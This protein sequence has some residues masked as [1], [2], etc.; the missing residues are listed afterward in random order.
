M[1]SRWSV[2]TAGLISLDQIHVP[3]RRGKMFATG[4]SCGNVSAN[5]AALGCE[6]YPLS[7]LGL[8]WQGE[9]VVNELRSLGA[10]MDF[11]TRRGDVRTPIVIHRIFGETG[12]GPDHD[13]L[14]VDPE[15]LA[16][17]PRF[18]SVDQLA[19][20]CV[21]GSGI[22]PSVFYL[23][24][25]SPEL[26]DAA[27]WV[28]ARSARVIFE[29][30]GIDDIALFRAIDGLADI[31]KYASHC[32]MDRN[33]NPLVDVKAPIEIQTLGAAEIRVGFRQQAQA[34][35]GVLTRD[36]HHLPAL[37]VKRL[38]DSA[39]A[40]DAVSTGL[41]WALVHEPHDGTSESHTVLRGLDQGRR[42]ASL[43]CGYYGAR[44]V[45]RERNRNEISQLMATG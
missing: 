35:G 18:Q 11:L 21:R 14:F 17:L 2:M 33:G 4:G 27:R 22:V 8:D 37:P 9:H 5:L 44:G 13:F 3:G 40:G 39:G 12:D 28:K 34:Q 43:N 42:L 26:L 15:T 16:P 24:R 1:S 23:D 19:I 6:V 30:L 36:W 25:A 38:L 10:R 20:D 29:P 7:V 31:V 32:L 45:F 41:V